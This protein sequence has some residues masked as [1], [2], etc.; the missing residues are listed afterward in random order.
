M[1]LLPAGFEAL[2]PFVAQWALATAPERD[3]SRGT[4]SA[5]DRQA[6]FDAAFPMLPA[7]LD[8][9]DHTPLADHDDAQTRLMRL[10]L[11]LAHVALAVESQTEDEPRHW[12]YRQT[13]PITRCPADA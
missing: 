6:F 7:A 8:Y 13:L 9:L 4:A 3:R 1:T 5:Q 2:E 10:C 11:S 12:T